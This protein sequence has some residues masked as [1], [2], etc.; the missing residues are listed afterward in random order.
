MTKLRL[1]LKNSARAALNSL[2]LITLVS[3]GCSSSIEPSFQREDIAQAICDISKEEYGID[4]RAKLFGHTLWVYLPVENILEKKDKPEKFIEK[5]EIKDS[6]SG[7]KDSSLTVK[8]AIKAIP[9]K[10]NSQEYG[11]NKEVMEK[12]NNIW[13]VT[14]RV[15]FSMERSDG[16]EPEFCVIVTADIKNGIV[17]KQTIYC[18]DL[19]KVSYGYIS[20]DEYQRRSITESYLSPEAFDDKEGLFLAYKDITMEEFIPLQI[21]YRVKLKFQRPDT[22][23]NADIDQEVR[24]I[25]EHTLKIYNF[26]GFSTLELENLLS[27]EKIRLKR[28]Q[29]LEEPKK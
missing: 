23:T 29:I 14:R 3:L 10:E 11:Y 13:K 8:Y 26:T 28:E 21:A 27:A 25:A 2:I 19:K 4:A 6:D 9:E 7:L 20:W 22:E 15:L 17:S 16:S 5:F 24:K 1:S 18:K 12:I